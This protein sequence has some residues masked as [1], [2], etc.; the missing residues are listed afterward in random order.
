[1]SDLDLP[2][3]TMEDVLTIERRVIIGRNMIYDDDDDDDDD[4]H[5]MMSR[6]VTNLSDSIC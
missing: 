1:M 2:K 5:L 4:N 6:A 3:F